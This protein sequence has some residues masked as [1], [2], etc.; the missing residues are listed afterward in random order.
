MWYILYDIQFMFTR[1]LPSDQKLSL[2]CH[3]PVY[4][5]IYGEESKLNLNLFLLLYMQDPC[6]KMSNLLSFLY[7]IF[8]YFT[9]SDVASEFWRSLGNVHLTL[10]LPRKLTPISDSTRVQWTRQPY[11]LLRGV[12]SKG[13]VIGPRRVV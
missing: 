6:H 5:R 9:I 4:M 8:C 2:G 12:I 11:Y 3:N 10:I 1:H 13:A 7:Y